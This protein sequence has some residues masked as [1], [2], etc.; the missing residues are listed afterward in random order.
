[1]WDRRRQESEA[2]SR[3]TSKSEA[4]RRLGAGVPPTLLWPPYSL[5]V[6]EGAA[7]PSRMNPQ[8][9]QPQ[10]HTGQETGVHSRAKEGEP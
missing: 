3:D 2:C 9:Q 7:S 10:L 8:H 1:M 5:H 6:C 4:R